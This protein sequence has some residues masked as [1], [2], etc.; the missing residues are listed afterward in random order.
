MKFLKISM[1]DSCFLKLFLKIVFENIDNV[2]YS[3]L[4]FVFFVFSR[5][6]KSGTKGVCRVLRVFLVFQIK[7]IVFKNRKQVGPKGSFGCENN[8]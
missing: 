8:F 3:Y 7:K 5:T 6:K 2:N 1:F 4:N